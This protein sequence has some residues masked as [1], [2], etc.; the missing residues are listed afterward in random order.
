VLASSVVAVAA[1]TV[2]MQDESANAKML[3]VILF[4]SNP[5]YNNNFNSQ[6]N[7]RMT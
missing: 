3:L 6:T 5:L 2:K 4:I 7:Y 1:D